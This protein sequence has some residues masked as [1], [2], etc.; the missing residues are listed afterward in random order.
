VDLLEA[1]IKAGLTS[2]AA[3]SMKMPYRR[4]WDLVDTTNHSFKQPVD[5]M[6]SSLILAVS[7]ESSNPSKALTKLTSSALVP[8]IT[9]K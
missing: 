2:A 8:V 6:V 3:I 9:S 4:A 7:L 5:K 1:I